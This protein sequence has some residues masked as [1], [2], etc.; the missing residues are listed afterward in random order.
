ML[1]GLENVGL[2]LVAICVLVLWLETLE[3]DLVLKDALFDLF[4]WEFD[5]LEFLEVF[6]EGVE[7]LGVLALDRVETVLVWEGQLDVLFGGKFLLEH[8]NLFWASLSHYS[9]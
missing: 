8:W 7:G 9:V 3:H 5:L 4:T 2:Y 6:L 1:V